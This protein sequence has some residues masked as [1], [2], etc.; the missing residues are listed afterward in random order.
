MKNI[1]TSASLAAI[2]LAMAM[3]NSAMASDNSANVNVKGVLV[4][5]CNIKMTLHD[6]HMTGR[7]QDFLPASDFSFD[8]LP[9]KIKV[10]TIDLTSCGE[11]FKA[12]LA[13][14]SKPI[15]GYGKVFSLV[16]TSG[17][18]TTDWG[19]GLIQKDGDSEVRQWNPSS[20]VTT[21][22]GGHKYEYLSGM[23]T[24]ANI[25]KLPDPGQYTGKMTFTVTP[26]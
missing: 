4:S 15:E 11:D 23:V 1:K 7:A 17:S 13:L 12:Q 20:P 24:A 25:S 8:A 16:D 18:A 14:G 5:G 3:A 6:I 19:F 10:G 9:T 26:E 22:Q 21:L 2:C